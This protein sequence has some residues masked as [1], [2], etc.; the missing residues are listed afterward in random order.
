M[1]NSL[2]SVDG[3][4]PCLL[5]LCQDVGGRMCVLIIR[6]CPVGLCRWTEPS[7]STGSSACLKMAYCIPFVRDNWSAIVVKYVRQ[8]EADGSNS[9]TWLSQGSEDGLDSGEGCCGSGPCLALVIAFNRPMWLYSPPMWC[10]WETP[11]WRLQPGPLKD[12]M[13][14]ATA[15]LHLPHGFGIVPLEP[16]GI[17]M[18]RANWQVG[19][20]PS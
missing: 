2:S 17:W 8:I 18:N 1:I 13:G 14:A 11:C 16:L 7:A 10:C 19:G 3:N 12:S 4:Y 15:A 9:D 6:H 20:G 5:R